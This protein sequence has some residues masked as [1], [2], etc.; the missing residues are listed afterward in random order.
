MDVVFC[1]GYSHNWFYFYVLMR[2]YFISQQSRMPAPLLPANIP[3]PARDERQRYGRTDLNKTEQKK[4][5]FP[6]AFLH[7]TREDP[8]F[9]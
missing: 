7:G 1:H 4:P 3:K 8:V 6:G 9:Q 2:N 5:G